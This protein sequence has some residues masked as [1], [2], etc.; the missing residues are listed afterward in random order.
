MRLALG[1]KELELVD[2]GESGCG[3]PEK[4]GQ[5]QGIACVGEGVAYLRDEL[6]VGTL[7]GTR[8]RSDNF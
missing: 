6:Q 4:G 7:S 8:V 5:S 3:T 1:R 2:L